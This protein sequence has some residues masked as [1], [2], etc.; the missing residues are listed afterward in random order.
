MVLSFS[1]R[2]DFIRLYPVDSIL[3]G[4]EK[5]KFIIALDAEN[6]PEKSMGV[7]VFP[8]FSRN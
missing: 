5:E 4:L 2:Y 7:G 8:F 3:E 6:T 1:S